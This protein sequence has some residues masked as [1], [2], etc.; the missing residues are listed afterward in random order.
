M[1]AALTLI[2]AIL[3]ICGFCALAEADPLSGGMLDPSAAIV[4]APFIITLPQQTREP[5]PGR[6]RKGDKLYD[7]RGRHIGYIKRVGMFGIIGDFF[8]GRSANAPGVGDK[9]YGD[10]GTYLGRTQIDGSTIRGKDP[11][12][13][14]FKN[15]PPRERDR[16]PGFSPVI[17]AP[18]EG[19]RQAVREPREPRVVERPQREP[20][21]NL[22]AHIDRPG[23]F[24][25]D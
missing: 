20:R 18:R 4:E 19:E 3:V 6:P 24:E 8:F 7:A 16:K 9:I 5:P 14:P 1:H 22:P 13:G 11:D 2:F 23:R 17:V 15:P 21:S 10:G 25:R 12:L